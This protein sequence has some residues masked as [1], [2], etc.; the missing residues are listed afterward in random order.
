SHR[1]RR[2]RG[3]AARRALPARHLLSPRRHRHGR[4]LTLEGARAD[5]EKRGGA[6][7]RASRTTLAPGAHPAAS[8]DG[9]IPLPGRGAGS[10]PAFMRI[11]TAAGREALFDELAS[12]PAY[13]EEAVR[14]LPGD[15]SLIRGPDECFCL[16]EQAW[17]LADLE[18]EGYAPRI[19]RL[20]EETQPQLPDFDGSRIARERDYRSL[21]LAEGLARFAAA[22]AANLAALRL[23]PEAAWQRGGVQEGIGAVMLA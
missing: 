15:R 13:L 1:G 6:R 2:P 22:R 21:S 9:G 7:G 4:P 12:M 14:A 19:R 16:V 10:G 17:H 20:L 18:R 11:G 3:L 5:P 8:R 23:V